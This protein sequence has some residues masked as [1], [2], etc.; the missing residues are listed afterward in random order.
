MH[1]PSAARRLAGLAVAA[2]VLQSLAT[3]SDSGATTVTLNR[4]VTG[5]TNPV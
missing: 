5:L 4:V 1:I 2:L 3:A